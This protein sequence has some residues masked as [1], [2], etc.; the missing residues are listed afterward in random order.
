MIFARI[1]LSLVLCFPAFAGRAD[2]IDTDSLKPWETCALCHG[3][4][5]VSQMGKFPKLANQPYAYLLKQL[6][7]FRAS[8]R[9]NDGGM[10]VNNVELLTP[11][12]L[13]AVACYFSALPP[14]PP[15]SEGSN[16]V[17]RTLFLNGKPDAQVPACQ[18]CHGANPPDETPYPRLEGQHA[19]YVTKQLRDFQEQARHN[20][21][22]QIMQRIASRLTASEISAVAA[23]V[24]GLER[25]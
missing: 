12:T 25:K 21:R 10:M 15:S 6:E 3:L 4:D 11:E 16:A 14:P 7:D 8:R 5:G 1:T 9:S 2:M 22:N 13:R 24:A 18:S 19:S 23:F 20:D 17:G